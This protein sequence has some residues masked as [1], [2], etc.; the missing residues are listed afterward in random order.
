MAGYP[1]SLKQ[2]TPARSRMEEVIR[3][4]PPDLV[5][6]DIAHLPGIDRLA[7]TGRLK[8]NPATSHIR[9]V[10]L[11][12]SAMRGDD[13][14]AGGPGCEG[15]VAEPIDTATNWRNKWRRFSTVLRKKGKGR[16]QVFSVGAER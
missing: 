13:Q 11:T 6:M 4:T 1:G 2:P 9:I 5:L 8:A 16:C 3:Q 15:C 12:T 7:L 14:K 10:A